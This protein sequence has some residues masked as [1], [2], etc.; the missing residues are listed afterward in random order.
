MVWNAY[1]DFVLPIQTA[2]LATATL[3]FI[4]LGASWWSVAISAAMTAMCAGATALDA[5][6]TVKETPRQ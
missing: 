5:V 4:L 6:L 3:V 1:L 2:I